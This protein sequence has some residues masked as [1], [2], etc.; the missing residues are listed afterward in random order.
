MFFGNNSRKAVNAHFD[1]LAAEL[2]RRNLDAIEA[3]FSPENLDSTMRRAWRLSML[4]RR[5][6]STSIYSNPF[7]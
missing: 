1:F 6:V 4:R 5:R 3:L 7:V 2:L